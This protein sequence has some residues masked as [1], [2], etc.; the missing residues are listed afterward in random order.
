MTS[1]LVPRTGTTVGRPPSGVVRHGSPGPVEDQLVAGAAVS[2]RARRVSQVSAPGVF[3]STVYPTVLG[4][5]LQGH[6]LE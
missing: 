3:S 5:C 6:A 2:G 1:H 4:R